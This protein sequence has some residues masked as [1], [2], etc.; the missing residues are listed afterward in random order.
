M[1]L[2]KTLKG[3]VWW[4]YERGSLHYDV[5]V[6][7]ILLFIFVTPHYVDFRDKPTAHIPHPTG[8]IVN[9]D[10]QGGF[11]YQVNAAAVADK[12]GSDLEAE[13]VRIIEPIS[14][15]VRLVGVKPVKDAKGKVTAYLVQA[16]R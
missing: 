15:E 16:H 4:T 9:P 8:V 10:G 6:T 5:M 3:Y 12:Q 13:L 11:F 1:G 2:G 14:G 7:L